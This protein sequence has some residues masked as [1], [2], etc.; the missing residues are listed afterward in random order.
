MRPVWLIEAGVYGAEAD[1]LLAEIRRQGMAAE[2]VPFQALLPGRA[3]VAGGRPLGDRDCVIGYGTFP[4]ARQLQL[5]RR[6]TPGAWCDPHNLD[7][8]T[9]FAHFGRFLLNQPYA[10]LPGV[11]AIRHRDWLFSV[12]S[13]EGKVF[14]R[15]AGCHK[16]FTGHRIGRDDFAAAL[17]PTRYDPTTLVVVAAPREI[18][19]EWRLV[20]AEDRVVAASQ[21]AVEGRK[22]VAPGCPGEVRAFA[23]ALLAEVGWRPDPLFLLDVCEAERRLWLVEINGFSTSWLYQC[24]LAAVVA[25]AAEL[26]SRAGPGR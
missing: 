22:C 1:P 6:W 17:A 2:V 10:L 16:L 25:T 5:H 7:C 9:Y 15:P 21:Y 11:E 13:Q 24:D 26:A 8:T 23:E 14:V 20:A 4:F 19:R 18:G 3:V 12:F